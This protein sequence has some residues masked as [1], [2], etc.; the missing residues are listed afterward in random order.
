MIIKIVGV[1]TVV[2][3]A[4][5]VDADADVVVDMDVDMV[6]R[7]LWCSIQEHGKFP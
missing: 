7:K 3:V 1:D 6:E 4:V 5:D 2:V